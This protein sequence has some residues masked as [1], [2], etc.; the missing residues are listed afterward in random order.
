MSPVA[1]RLGVPTQDPC[2]PRPE[3][4]GSGRVDPGLVLFE[5]SLEESVTLIPGRATLAPASLEVAAVSGLQNSVR[6]LEMTD[7]E[8]EHPDSAHNLTPER[9]GDGRVEGKEEQTKINTYVISDSI[10][11][12]G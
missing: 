10:L 1:E 3:G 12:Q 4:A 9:E 11:A 7:L 6:V 5:A 2:A 8:L